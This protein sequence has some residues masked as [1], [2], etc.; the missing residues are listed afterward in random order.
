MVLRVTLV[1][2]LLLLLYPILV[3]PLKQ[4]SGTDV[5]GLGIKEYD[6]FWGFHPPKD[7]CCGHCGWWPH[8]P[9]LSSSAKHPQ[10]EQPSGAPT[11]T[12]RMTQWSPPS[13]P[14]GSR[15]SF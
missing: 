13:L 10:L 6:G 12:S 14:P 1:L 3:V 8:A 9:F 5:T 7:T 15:A 2:A 11:V 4:G